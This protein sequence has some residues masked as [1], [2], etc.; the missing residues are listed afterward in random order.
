MEVL[1]WLVLFILTIS[2]AWLLSILYQRRV[3][4][5]FSASF[6][7]PGKLY[8]VEGAAIHLHCT[9]T[10]D[11]PVILEAGSGMWS[12][13]WH[14]VHEALAESTMVCSYDR[15][16]HGWSDFGKQPRSIEQLV[17]ELHGV[18][19]AAE[20]PKPFILVGASFGG[21]IIQ[22]YEQQYPD[23]VA[24][25]VLVDARP[26]SYLEAFKEV[27][28]AAIDEHVSRQRL[29]AKLYELGLLA[30]IAKLQGQPDFNEP[31]QD[32]RATYQDLGR[33]T[34]HAAASSYEAMADEISDHQMQKISSVGDK[35]L[36]VIAHGKRT[37]FHG[38]LGLTDSEA[39]QLED[40]WRKEQEA[41]TSLSS[42]S[43]FLVGENSGHLICMEQPEIVVEAVRKM[44]A[45]ALK[46][47]NRQRKPRGL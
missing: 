41:L 45:A 18:L 38:Q 1:I 43:E 24:G 34:K 29:I 37:M 13:D 42:S 4:S 36:T 3:I 39:Q 22:L 32:L 26:S 11:V 30:L 9:G 46:K 17:S 8:R 47:S 20:I 21:A 12:L 5:R 2:A 27:R 33:L 14:E 6:P 35:P 28:P 10:G 7:A 19:A 15:A 31:P 23:D 16:G 44:L 40:I 25:M